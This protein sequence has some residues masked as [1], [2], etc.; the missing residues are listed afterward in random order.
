MHVDIIFLIYA[1]L[2]IRV[3]VVYTCLLPNFPPCVSPVCAVQGKPFAIY[4]FG[5]AVRFKNNFADAIS[6]VGL[7]TTAAGSEGAGGAVANRPL[8]C[9]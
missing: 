1:L 3:T 6:E 5:D 2:S 7:M 8:S 4:G 9:T